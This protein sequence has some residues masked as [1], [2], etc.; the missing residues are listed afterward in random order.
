M[1]PP[2]NEWIAGQKEDIESTQGSFLMLHVTS[3]YTEFTHP[4]ILLN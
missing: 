3:T 4:L 2:Q 1:K